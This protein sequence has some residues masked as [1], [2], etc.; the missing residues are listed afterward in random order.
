VKFKDER[1]KRVPGPIAD[2]DPGTVVQ[3]KES[4]VLGLVVVGLDGR[5]FFADLRHGAEQHG[6]TPDG[7]CY[8]VEA[9]VTITD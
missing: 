5:K 3:L 2:V 6:V 4:G 7:L 9:T 1:L 8:A